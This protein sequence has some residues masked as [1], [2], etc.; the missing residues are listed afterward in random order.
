MEQLNRQ[1][2]SGILPQQ[3]NYTVDNNI[4]DYSKL[5]YNSRYHTFEFFANKFPKGFSEDPLFIPII[6]NMAEQA[7][8]KNQSPLKELDELNNI[9]NNSI[10]NNVVSDSFK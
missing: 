5:Q 9:L 4:I 6:E 7:K 3:L 1:L 8:L 10:D 2:R